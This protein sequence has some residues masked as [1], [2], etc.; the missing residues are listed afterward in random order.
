MIEN[1][2]NMHEE[3]EKEMSELVNF[4]IIFW[5]FREIKFFGWWIR[6][7]YVKKEEKM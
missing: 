2:T 5:V 7:I 3:S 1:T 6:K 4:S